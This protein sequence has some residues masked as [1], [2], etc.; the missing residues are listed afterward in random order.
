LLAKS[1]CTI[2]A[3]VWVGLAG[4]CS[5]PILGEYRFLQPDKTIAKPDQ[6]QV[7]WII[8]DMGELDKADEVY[9][10]ATKPGPQ[11]WV[12]VDE[13]YAI[14]PM[15]DL[16]ISIMDLYAEGME[17]TLPRRVSDSGYIDLP[18]LDN[19][20]AA[21]GL[22]SIQLT[23]VIK[24]AYSKNILRD[25]QVSVTVTVRR[26]QTFSLLGA[27]AR[28]GAYPF[29][30]KD[31]RMLDA[32]AMA[33]GITQ[34]GIET[35]YVIRQA[36]ARSRSQASLSPSTSTSAPATQATPETHNPASATAMMH[37]SETASGGSKQAP[38]SQPTQAASYR[39]TYRDGE[40]VK[41]A[42]EP[43]DKA[44]AA[45]PATR[46]GP[47]D[48]SAGKGTKNRKTAQK[49]GQAKDAS[50]P[51]G[52][53]K[54]EKNDLVR[55]ISIDLEKLRQGDYRQNVVIHANDIIHIPPL[56]IGEFYVMG[57]VLRPG[58][59]SLT[60][61]K[62]TI[63]MA[64]AAAGNLGPLAWPSNSILIRR[65]GKNQEQSIPVNIENIMTGKDPDLYLKKNDIIAVGT[66]WSS[67]FLAVL[68]NAFR[69]TYGFGFI[70]D[71]NFS[72]PMIEGTPTS[73]RFKA[74]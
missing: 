50:D 63:K 36:P 53:A 31:M 15:D 8:Q 32:L 67:S 40:W 29:P 49:Q 2:L 58:V 9:P 46:P 62:V 57:E 47:A 52:W 60:G 38:A 41:V 30:R 39:W 11:D 25:P 22:T 6:T 18:Q 65:I 21:A 26:Q 23:E 45:K 5:Q 68:R 4:G 61:R 34:P 59:Y 44:P 66:H 14:A 69:M 12:Y 35:I 73:R 71:R 56:P 55:I 1:V 33:G 42:I 24:K 27:I 3:A 17:T 7:N 72:D 19:R 51:F 28:P 10:N 20:I 48:K 37:L 16:S 74:W 54:M 43:K 64:L 13:D 70:Y